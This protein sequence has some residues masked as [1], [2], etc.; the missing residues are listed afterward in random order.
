LGNEELSQTSLVEHVI[1][2]EGHEPIRSKPRQP[3]HHL[4]G[5]IE[6]MVKSFLDN[7]LARCSNS[8]WA[9]PIVMVRKKDGSLR[10]CVDYRNVN[11]VTRKDAFPLP[12]INNTLMN[13]GKKRFLRLSICSQ[14]TIKYEW[15]L[16]Q[17]TRLL[18]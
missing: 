8:P 18:L 3:P 4:K 16:I 1:D 10:F 15:I 7:N 13:I 11:A 9:S 6:E 17:L 14:A 2:V 12:H 5:K